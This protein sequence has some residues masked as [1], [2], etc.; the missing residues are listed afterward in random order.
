MHFSELKIV[1]RRLDV[2]KKLIWVE[3][4][5]Y[6]SLYIFKNVLKNYVPSFNCLNKKNSETSEVIFLEFKAAP[7]PQKPNLGYRTLLVKILKLYQL[8]E[9]PKKP[10]SSVCTSCLRI[11]PFLHLLHSDQETEDTGS[12]SKQGRG[13]TSAESR[14]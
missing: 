5:R 1:G 14:Q 6:L 10:A 9:E 8:V 7:L 4:Y 2:P 12:K 11:S 3:L 13:K